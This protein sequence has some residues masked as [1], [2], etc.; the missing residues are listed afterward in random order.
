MA[1]FGY[2]LFFVL[3]LFV[4]LVAGRIAIPP[5][6][7]PGDWDTVPGGASQLIGFTCDVFHGVCYFTGGPASNGPYGAECTNTA[8]CILIPG[9][10]GSCPTMY[11]MNVSLRLLL[12]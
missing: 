12:L 4:V 1:Y 10:N 9:A 3:L 6:P 7:P 2:F 8:S 5:F 11:P